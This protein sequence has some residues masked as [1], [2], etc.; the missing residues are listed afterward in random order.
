MRSKEMKRRAAGDKLTQWLMC[1][2]MLVCMSHNNEDNSMPATPN[3]FKCHLCA[4]PYHTMPWTLHGLA[5]LIHK[6]YVSLG[7]LQLCGLDLFWT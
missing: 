2:L 4:R 3:T 5:Y 7:C 6:K 1:L